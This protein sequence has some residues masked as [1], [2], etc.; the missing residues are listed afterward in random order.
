MSY[1]KSP[2][3]QPQSRHEGGNELFWYQAV[4]MF[5]PAVNMGDYRDCGFQHVRAGSSSF[6][7]QRLLLAR[8][9]AA[10]AQQNEM[11]LH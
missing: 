2:P 8:H 3:P 10:I 6:R 7:P 4:N 9:I 11:G 5:L 1:T